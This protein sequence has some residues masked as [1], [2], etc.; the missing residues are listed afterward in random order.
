MPSPRRPQLVPNENC[1]ALL[2]NLDSPLLTGHNYYLYLHPKTHQF[3]WIPWDLNEAFAGFAPGGDPGEQMNLSVD[4]PYSKAFIKQRVE[5]VQL[6]L[7]GKTSG[8]EPREMR[9]GPNAPRPGGP[10]MGPPL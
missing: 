2:S 6:Q 5:S 10:P 8:Y 9:R 4:H 7:E 1:W 3:V